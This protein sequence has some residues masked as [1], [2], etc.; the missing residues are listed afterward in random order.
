MRFQACAWIPRYK[1]R[2]T[3]KNCKLFGLV[4]KKGAQKQAAGAEARELGRGQMVKVL[5]CQAKEL[6]LE[7][8]S[9][10]ETLKGFKQGSN[11]MAFG[12]S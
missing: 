5:V 3:Q 7:L 8:D 9:D 11:M 1:T 12:T 6:E 4:R 2:F 10:R